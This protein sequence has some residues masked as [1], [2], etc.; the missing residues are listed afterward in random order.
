MKI[1]GLSKRNITIS[2][3]LIVIVLLIIMI[4]TTSK[5]TFEALKH[6]KALYLLLALLSWICYITFDGLRF[7]FAALSIGEK[8]L[9]LFTSVKII[10]IG[11]FLAA[12]S[13]F[14][15]AGLPVQIMLLNKRKIGVGKSTALLASRGFIAYTTVLIAVVISLKYIWPPPSGIVKGVI[16]YATTI[17][18]AI[19]LLYGFAIF[20]PKLLKKIIK[21]EKIL[22]EILSLRDTTI[23]F[24]KNS[25]KRLLLLSYIAS[26]ICHISLCSI[27]FFLSRAFNSQIWFSKA[28]A[29]Q[30]LIQ[31]GL[32]W[33]PTP[34][35]T[36]IA[37]GVGLFVFKDFMLPEILGIFIIG[38]R[39][40]TH[41]FTAILGA[42]LFLPEIREF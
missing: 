34:G 7:T 41:H 35:G 11:I 2:V 19:F 12:V 29:F 18:G 25:D 38:W 23:A 13:P 5:E 6:A 33:T 26:F 20:A 36:G 10:T 30:S 17:V 42:I 14:Q 27:P 28:F 31:G 15:V 16:I 22:T 9:N 39:F 37:E 8:R 1:P 24:V 32:L 3:S 4:K 21:S 40:F